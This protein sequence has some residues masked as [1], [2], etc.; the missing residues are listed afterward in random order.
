MESLKTAPMSNSKTMGK[1]TNNKQYQETKVH[2][3]C[4]SS[5]DLFHTHMSNF[6]PKT[7]EILYEKR[8][9]LEM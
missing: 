8:F 9:C 3:S 7:V 2:T 4:S 5:R 6:L 1:D